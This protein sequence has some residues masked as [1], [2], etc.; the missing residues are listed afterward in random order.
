MELDQS[1]EKVSDTRT[2]LSLLE[3]NVAIVTHSVEKLETKIEWHPVIISGSK[4][5]VY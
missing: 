1:R 3:N 2:R 5:S 4:I